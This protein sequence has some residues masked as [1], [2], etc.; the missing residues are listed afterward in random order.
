MFMRFR[1]SVSF[2]SETRPVHTVRGEFDKVDPESAFKSAVFL[3]FK[4]A[5]K[6]I[7]RSW[8]VVIEHL[9]AK[10]RHHAQSHRQEGAYDRSEGR[11][12]E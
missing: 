10:D 5:P 2:E 4:T 9:T 7:Y 12:L 11:P 3:A 8:V 1:Y 6:G